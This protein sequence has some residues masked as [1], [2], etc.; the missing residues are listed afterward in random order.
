MSHPQSS[1]QISVQFLT[2]LNPDGAS[3]LC[4]VIS[5]DSVA[6]ARCC[7]KM[8]SRTSQNARVGVC[9]ERKKG[10][11]IRENVKTFSC[12]SGLNGYVILLKELEVKLKT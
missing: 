8:P 9:E 1:S 7:M 10:K 2:T 5:S 6:C 11:I 4:N 3:S 12:G